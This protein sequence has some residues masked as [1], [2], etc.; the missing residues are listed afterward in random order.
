MNQQPIDVIIQID[1]GSRWLRFDAP[2][3]VIDLWFALFD[4]A[5]VKDIAAPAPSNSSSFE[6]GECRPQMACGDVISVIPDRLH[7][8]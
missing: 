5:H 3:R 6:I 1:R 4:E 7:H 8:R 2:A